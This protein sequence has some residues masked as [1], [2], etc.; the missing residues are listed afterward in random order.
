MKFWLIHHQ[1]LEM[2]EYT[3]PKFGE[4]SLNFILLIVK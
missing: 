1:S 4:Q 2:E 3:C